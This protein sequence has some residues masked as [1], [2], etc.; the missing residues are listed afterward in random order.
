MIAA[1]AIAV[2]RLQGHHALA[3]GG[4]LRPLVVVDDRGDDVAAEGRANLQQQVLVLHLGLGVGHVAD[5]QIG[6]VGRQAGP[7]R[8]GDAGGQIA[9]HRRGADDDDL[10]PVLLDQRRQHPGVRQRLIV[11]Q[12]RMLGQVDAVDAVGDKPLGQRARRRRPAIPRRRA[13]PSRSA[14]SRALPQSSKRHVAERTVFLFGE[15]PDFAL[16][17]WFCHSYSW[18][19]VGAGRPEGRPP[20]A[21]S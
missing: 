10:R 2:G 11:G 15:D 4:H 19:V 14:R 21:E 13:T 7:Q 8:R 20:S 5:V 12:P 1:G 9:A 18:S 6:A 17:V 3:H 16:A